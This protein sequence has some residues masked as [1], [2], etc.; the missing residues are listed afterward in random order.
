MK[1]EFSDK[2]CV[3]SRGGCRRLAVGDKEM[4]AQGRG[5]QGFAGPWPWMWLPLEVR[6]ESLTLCRWSELSQIAGSEGERWE[7]WTA[8]GQRD[9]IQKTGTAA[10][11]LKELSLVACLQCL[12]QFFGF[13][14][15]VSPDSLL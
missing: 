8:E 4:R 14:W 12:A 7:S 15:H 9:R 11:V 6:K 1:A 3:A 10:L 5:L 2:S 13:T